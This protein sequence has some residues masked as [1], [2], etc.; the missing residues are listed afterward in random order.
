[1]ANIP[2]IRSLARELGLSVATISEA[3][4]DS[5]RVKLATRQRVK[6]AAKKAGYNPNPLLGATFS[7]LRRSRHTNFFGTL[8][9]VDVAENGRPELMI[10]HREVAKGA[11]ARARELGFRTEVF[12]LGP[13][14]P[15]LSPARLNSVLQARNIPGMVLMPF[16]QVVDLSGFD[17]T[18]VAAVQMDHCLAQPRL[19]NVVPDH[20]LSMMHALERLT[21][22]GYRRI[23]LCLEQR[24]D[25]RLKS[26]WSSGF[27]AFYRGFDRE[28][29]IPPLIDPA[30]GREQFLS[31]FRNYKPDVVV[32]HLQVVAQW[33][34][35]TGV[36][37]PE[38]VGFFK[39]NTTERTAPCAGL[40]LQPRQLGAAAVETAVG[41]IHR[42]EQGAPSH[43]MTISLEAEWVDGPTLR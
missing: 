17:F 29:G 2:T 25:V 39:L 13:K 27:F 18:H 36:R 20:Y 33:L 30:P 21:Q 32:A 40:D 35:E 37:V 4:R 1:M 41:M 24:K 42:R 3:L 15:M 10:F 5:P 38:D 9:L 12:W 11:E 26:N 43:P 22:R 7:A 6:R 16:S 8:G 31:W 34:R 19:H 28:A 14:A 23:G